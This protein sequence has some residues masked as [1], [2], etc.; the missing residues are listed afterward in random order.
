MMLQG[1]SMN[2][3]LSSAGSLRK[4]VEDQAANTH[5]L[6]FPFFFCVFEFWGWLLKMLSLNIDKF[7]YELTINPIWG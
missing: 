1:L 6:S 2:W 5:A 7:L 3:L 4:A